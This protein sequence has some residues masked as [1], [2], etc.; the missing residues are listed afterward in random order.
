M[1]FWLA[2]YYNKGWNDNNLN[3]WSAISIYE[4]LV[5]MFNDKN[6]I[7]ISIQMTPTSFDH[8]ILRK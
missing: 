1:V 3:I 2:D 6:K 5:G 7:Y 8:A 4:N